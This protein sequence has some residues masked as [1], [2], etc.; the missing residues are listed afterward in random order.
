MIKHN[1]IFLI[2]KIK[3]N[4]AE[5]ICQTH[6]ESMGCDV[7]Y[8]GVEHLSNHF[9]MMTDHKRKQVKNLK[10]LFQKMPD[11]LIT[12]TV[13]NDAALVEVKFNKNIKNEKD[14]IEYS[15]VLHEK[16]KHIINLELPVY[17]YLVTN[18]KPYVFIMKANVEGGRPGGFYKADDSKL[19][20]YYFFTAEKSFTEV[21]KN[22]ILPALSDIFN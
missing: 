6:F 12:N 18:T 21:Y 8:I 3:G 10:D 14:L 22:I 5:N 4:F 11:F 2:N 17:F 1:D 19:D 9:A 15:K 16:Y 20:G 13:R 7:S